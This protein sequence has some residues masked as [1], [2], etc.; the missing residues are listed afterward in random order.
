MKQH[1]RFFNMY[2]TTTI[3]I[4]LVLCLIGL[5]CIVLL[6]AHELVR[7]IRENVAL[8]V[9]MSN[10]AS[11]EDISRMERLLKAAPYCHDYRYISREAALQEHITNLG[12]D[13]QKFLGYNPLSDAYELHINAEFAQ[14]D[15]IEIIQTRLTSL[16]YV[17]KVVYQKD[18][19]KM[20]D[21]NI[22]EASLILL[23]IATA[24][25]IIALVL[26]S[27]TIQ[28]QVYSR[29]FLINTMRLV[30][31]TPWVIKWP[32]IRRN[33]RMGV[34]ASILAL[35]VLTGVFYYCKVRL[36]IVLFPLTWQ[37]ITFV[38][39]VVLISGVAIT[40]FASWAATNRYIRMKI[41]KMY[42]I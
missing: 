34:E 19:V 33:M 20:L 31:A 4:A 36:G 39:A 11:T 38:I 10:D 32:F 1:R 16:P 8:T 6:S 7:H 26:I 22:G 12:E 21:S 37:N 30:G 13:P 41:N 3:S 42:E 23:A 29:R 5:E 15:S 27:N 35:L 9:V 18:V 14:V 28:L 24:L 17:D 2:L 25:L 40:F